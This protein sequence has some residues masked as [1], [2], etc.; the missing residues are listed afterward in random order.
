MKISQLSTESGIPLPTI[1]MYLREGL[2]PPGERTGV[3]QADYS[4]DHLRRLSVITGL[5]RVG[6]LSIAAARSVLEA[7]T[8]DIPLAYTL[9]VAQQAASALVNPADVDIRD[10]KAADEIMS[11]WLYSSDG[12]GR[13]GVAQVLAALTAS[14]LPADPRWLER[15]AEA[16][17]VVAEADLDLIDTRESREEKS[18]TVVIGTVLGDALFAALRRAAQEHV[19]NKR[20]N[21]PSE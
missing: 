12:P 9:G 16:A 19:S 14:G 13:L 4:A 2:L 1:K 11:P 5:I 21:Q 20:Y 18:E 7:A 8:S 3:N 10:L 6:G 17:L 15:Y